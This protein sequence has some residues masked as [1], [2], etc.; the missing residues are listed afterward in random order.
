MKYYAIYNVNISYI[1]TWGATTNTSVTPGVHRLGVHRPWGA[2]TDIPL[3][4]ARKCKLL[5]TN[6]LLIQYL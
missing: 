2:S 6:N 3:P 4:Q 5:S 1:Y